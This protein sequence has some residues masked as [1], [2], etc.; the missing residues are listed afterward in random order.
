MNNKQLIYFYYDHS[1]YLKY[2]IYFHFGLDLALR[3]IT[4]CSSSLTI[5]LELTNHPQKL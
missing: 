2:L 5:L 4:P 1:T 3:I